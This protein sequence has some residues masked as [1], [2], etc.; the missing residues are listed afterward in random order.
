MTPIA[1]IAGIPLEETLAYAGPVLVAVLAAA[2]QSLYRR[3][4]AATERGAAR[5]PGRR[6]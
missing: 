5:T 1:H 4:A 6:G 3:S 2:R